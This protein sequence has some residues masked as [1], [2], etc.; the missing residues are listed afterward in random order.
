MASAVTEKKA[1]SASQPESG[2]LWGVGEMQ[3]WR[4][5][6]EDAYV[7]MGSLAAGTGLQGEA[8]HE[9]A[10]YGLFGVFDGHGGAQV[11]KFCAEHLPKV[12]TN[13]RAAQAPA[14]LNES[15]FTVDQMLVDV[16]SKMSP[17][18]RGH[19][20]YVGCTAVASLI[21]KDFII[22]ANAGDSRAVLSRSGR[23]C[24]LSKDHKPNHEKEVARISKAGGFVSEQ[25]CGPHSIHRVN[26]E[27]AVS[28]AMGDLRFKK[29]TN[30]GVAE[31]AVSCA[32]DINICKRQVDDEFLVVACDGIWD[33]L[34][35]QEVVNLVRKDLAA[36]HRGDLKPADVVCKILDRC[37]SSDPSKSFGK[38]GDN[39][40][41]ILVVFDGA[42]LPAQRRQQGQRHIMPDCMRPAVEPHQQGARAAKD[43]SKVKGAQK[44][45]LGNKLGAAQVLDNAD[46]D[47]SNVVQGGW[48]QKKLARFGGLAQ[49]F[50][51]ARL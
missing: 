25:Q 10:D 43:R 4:P 9:W 14:A 50:N 19:P 2:L 28:R 38:G 48:L 27:L 36:I 18:D 20:D 11:S 6:M 16:G 22:V 23:A 51:N 13:G 30:V 35:S 5:T 32:P 45:V 24:D 31:Q 26:G 34:S 41:M 17:N 44:P 46:D 47:S 7:A 49:R 37:L 15:F 29:N 8:Q 40:T 21:R 1:H 42:G 39:M 3:G 33:V 12:V